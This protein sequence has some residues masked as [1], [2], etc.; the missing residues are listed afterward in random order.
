MKKKLD[1][2]FLAAG[3]VM[4]IVFIIIANF[5]TTPSYPWF[6]YPAIALL[7][8]TVSLILGKRGEYFK[9]SLYDSTFLL[10]FFIV[11]NY[12][13]TPD[14]PWF[15]FVL[16]PIVLWP[17]LMFLGHKAK[18]LNTALIGSLGI[19]FYYSILN[20]LLFPQYIWVIYIAFPVLW[21]PLAVYHVKNKTYFN[22]S[23]HAS[24]F[25]S[26]FFIIVNMINSPQTI[27]AVYPIFIVLWWPL[28]MY[29]FY[30]K[31]IN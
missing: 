31:K 16:G 10:I 6:I 23:V 5:L 15:L 8:S 13:H 17:I 20:M 14:Y 19:I 27:W 7:F 28:S 18:S 9:L 24:L 12:M 1:K 2:G 4:T 29:Y 22:F 25:I 21:W 3:S 11:V 26:L 30:Y